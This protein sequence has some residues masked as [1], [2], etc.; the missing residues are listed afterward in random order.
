VTR[1]YLA[2]L[3]VAADRLRTTSY[4][5]ERPLGPGHDEAAFAKNRR[6]HFAVSR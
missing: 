3:G 2:S 1:D 6:A 5:K 4:G